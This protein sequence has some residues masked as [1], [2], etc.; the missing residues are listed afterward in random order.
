MEEWSNENK[1]QTCSSTGFIGY[2]GNRAVHECNGS[3]PEQAIGQQYQKQFKQQLGQYQNQRKQYYIF[4]GDKY[5]IIYIT[6]GTDLFFK[7]CG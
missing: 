2:D 3:T 6:V 1:S 5:H 4:R 7:Y